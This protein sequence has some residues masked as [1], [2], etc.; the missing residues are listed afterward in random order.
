[1]STVGIIAEYNPF[2]NGHRYQIEQAKALTGADHAV[3]VM[4]GDYVQRGAPAIFGKALRAES[5][6]SCGADLVLEMP[7]FGA[8]SP[9]A[10]F[11]ACGVSLLE[12]AGIADFL[13]FGSETGDLNALSRQ[14]ELADSETEAVSAAIRK[15]LREGLTW[16]QARAKAY[17]EAGQPSGGAIFCGANPN[18]TMPDGTGPCS[19]NSYGANPDSPA[20][21]DATP[22]NTNPTI[23][24]TPNDILAVEYLRALKK[25]GSAIRP[26]PVRRIGSGYHSE[27]SDG[28]FSSATAARNAILSH[29][30][31]TLRRILPPES[32][33]LAAGAEDGAYP[34]LVFDDFSVLLNHKLLISSPEALRAVSSM[35]DDLAAKLYRHRLEFKKAAELAAASKDRQYTYTRVCR[36]LT[37]L[38]LDITKEDTEA[39]KAEQSAPWL[40][41]LGFRRDAAALLTALKKNASVPV[42]SKTADAETLL[43]DRVI[44]LWRKHLSASEL[45]RM[46]AESKCG[47]TLR[48]EFTTPPVIIEV[49]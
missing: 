33:R 11:A 2:H 43:P 20:S 19:V 38:L 47:R 45:Y 25:T 23:P 10:D 17:K 30:T 9:A 44:P 42:I 26:V 40:R 16:P 34:A 4:S 6:L 32:F 13:C 28:P 27:S 15:G 1:M 12:K 48:N 31:E 36:C 7:V 49:P 29:D 35:P 5:A 24:D 46:V 21:A 39:F 8:V 14:A 41:I 3:V 18:S 37:N 22:D